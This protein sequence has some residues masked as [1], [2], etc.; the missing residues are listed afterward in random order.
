MLTS[1]RFLLGLL[2]PVLIGLAGCVIPNTVSPGNLSVAKAAQA[3]LATLPVLKLNL[4][5]SLSGQ[6]TGTKSLSRT[7]GDTTDLSTATL[8]TLKSQA[9]YDLQ[10]NGGNPFLSVIN[11]AFTLVRSYASNNTI[12]E[13]TVFSI[14]LN[15]TNLADIF[16]S[17]PPPTITFDNQFKVTGT[18]TSNFQIFFK[19]L[20]HDSASTMQATVQGRFDIAG[21]GTN[22]QI[23]MYFLIQS[24]MGSQ[25]QTMPFYAFYDAATGSCEFVT[26][27]DGIMTSTSTVNSVTTTTTTPYHVDSIQKSIAVGGG[28]MTNMNVSKQT[29]GSNHSTYVNVSYGDDSAGGIASLSDYSG[30]SGQY[31]WGEYYDGS[32]NLLLRSNGNSQLW[33]PDANGNVIINAK[34]YG[35]TSPPTNLEVTSVSASDGTNWVTTRTLKDSSGNPNNVE[36]YYWD[37]V[38][39]KY[40]DQVYDSATSS[41]V[42]LP[43]NTWT[44]IA[45]KSAG[46]WTAGDAIYYWQSGTYD[47]ATNAWVETLYQGYVVPASVQKFGHAF[48]LT[49]EYPLVQIMPLTAAYAANYKLIQEEGNTYTGTWTDND[50]VQQPWSWTN[51]SFYLNKN[52]PGESPIRMD[53][54]AGDINFNDKL[55]QYDMYY[56]HNGT[57]T[58]EKGYFYRTTGALP[59]YFTQPSTTL[60]NQVDG[61]LQAAMG[62]ALALDGTAYTA[63]LAICL[64]GPATGAFVP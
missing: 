30:G 42:T 56:W 55:Q 31:Y 17:A 62:S 26:S 37:S 23:K 20:M 43:A 16:G 47:N 38:G 53:A 64:A 9:W 54:A 27:F 2:V 24:T 44:S 52:Q 8:P 6:S 14:P 51:Y 7:L 1:Q 11:K 59:P 12:T 21:T 15:A 33:T 32:G 35:F 48:Y 29:S 4:P 18:D 40:V 57:T 60:V 61:N 25:S 19:V 49:N 45:Y 36:K 50:G 5:G 22:Q 63:P 39:N 10:G 13:N 3:A 58:K 28:A 41:W 46:G 34:D